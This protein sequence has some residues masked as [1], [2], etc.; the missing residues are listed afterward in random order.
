MPSARGA[1]ESFKR[2]RLVSSS[3][4][5]Q[6]PTVVREVRLWRSLVLLAEPAA[7]GAEAVP[8]GASFASGPA[9]KLVYE[10]DEAYTAYVE[11]F[12]DLPSEAQLLALQAVDT[13]VAAMVAEKDASLWTEGAR[14][15]H[16]SWTELR[17]LAARVLAEFAWPDRV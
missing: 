1:R 3:K 10:F 11:A 13:R 9:D 5:L 16:A 12:V 4:S 14:R 15:D 17:T 8:A 2:S 6:P 7:E